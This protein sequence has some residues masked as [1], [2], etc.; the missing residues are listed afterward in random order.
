MDLILCPLGRRHPCRHPTLPYSKVPR[1]TGVEQIRNFTR[2]P[3]PEHLRIQVI[4]NVQVD[5]HFRIPAWMEDGSAI[6][7]GLGLSPMAL[8]NVKHP[9]SF[10]EIA[11][12]QVFTAIDG[13]WGPPAQAIPGCGRSSSR[14]LA[15]AGGRWVGRQTYSCPTGSHQ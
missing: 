4:R 5:L 8:Y 12:K 7:P 1:R 15:Q 2:P 3:G 11:Y 9:P 10:I 13:I 14:R 6:L